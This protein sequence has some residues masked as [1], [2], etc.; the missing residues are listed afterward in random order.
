MSLELA[1]VGINLRLAEPATRAIAGDVLKSLSP[2]VHGRSATITGAIL[3]YDAGEVARRV[4]SD[5]KLLQSGDSG[6]DQGAEVFA[7]PDGSRF[8]WINELW[9]LCEIDL[10]KRRFIS[11]VLDRP[12]LGGIELMESAVYV[13][14]SHLLQPHGV[15]L[16]PAVS[17][18]QRGRGVLV[19][20][21]FALD[22]AIRAMA[23]FGVGVLG[24]RWTC[25]A[26]DPQSGQWQLRYVPGRTLCPVSP[27]RRTVGDAA[28]LGLRYDASSPLMRRQPASCELVLSLDLMRGKSTSAKPVPKLE[29][30]N[31]LRERWP[32]SDLRAP[33]KLRRDAI[34]HP[35]QWLA[36]NVPVHQVRLAR[37]ADHLARLL[38][39][40]SK[41]KAA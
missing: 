33:G 22:N 15:H 24:Q 28:S 21:P 41:S 20:T 4:S 12:R 3:P 14:L 10:I 32:I 5:A 23:D 40:Q 26:R 29:A 8:W 17:L 18:A 19:L 37:V 38:V 16:I 35:T 25:V 30:G 13:P 7:M 39:R 9:G 2:V 36:G 34:D 27:A 1:G 11:F 31:L 6:F